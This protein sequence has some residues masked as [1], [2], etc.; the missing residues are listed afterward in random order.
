MRTAC[1][2]RLGSRAAGKEK[3]R[4]SHGEAPSFCTKLAGPGPDRADQ[5]MFL[6]IAL[7]SSRTLPAASFRVVGSV[8]HHRGGRR[9]RRVV[10]DRAHV[11]GLILKAVGD[12]VTVVDD[13]PPAP[14]SCGTRPRTSDRRQREQRQ[15]SSCGCSQACNRGRPECRRVP[16]L[17]TAACHR[18]IRK[19]V[20]PP[21]ALGRQPA[22]SLPAR[23]RRSLASSPRRRRSGVTAPG[24]PDPA[25]P[26][27]YGGNRN[28][29][30]R[31]G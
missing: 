1:P 28:S 7:A 19:M 29:V 23:R 9:V 25:C 31:P 15:S 5:C 14:G 22:R 6:A 8:R 21:S 10:G 3:G 27:A 12:H 13:G 30:G 17:I 11:I 24:R 26:P 4:S 18:S 20:P 16:A 2:H